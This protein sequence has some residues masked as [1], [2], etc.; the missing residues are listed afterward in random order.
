MALRPLSDLRDYQ[1][2]AVERMVEGKKMAALLRPGLGKTACTLT[3]L[4]LLKPKRTLVVAPAQVVASEVWSREARAWGHTSHL[5]VSEILGS[6]QDR[7][8]FLLQG[9]DIEVISYDNLMWL[10]DTVLKGRYDA[11]VFD[12]LSKM[13]H[14]GTKRFKR[15]RAW[16][17]DIPIRFGLTGSPVGNHYLDLWGE[18]FMVAGEKPLGPTMGQYQDTYFRQDGFRWSIRQDGSVEQIKARIKPFA[19]SL[20]AKLSANQLPEVIHNPIKLKLPKE[21]LDLERQ[22]RKELEIE[23]ESGKTITALNNSKLA[24]AIRQLSSGAIYTCGPEITPRTWE[25][26]H[27]LKLEALRNL[28]DELQGEPLLVFTWF[29]HEAAR[30]QRDF[31]ARVLDGSTKMIDE[32][33]NRT[34]PILVAHPMGS[35]HGLNLQRGGSN[36]V[37][38]TPP[39]SRELFDQGNGRVA[40]IGQSSKLVSA[41]ILLA[42]SIDQRVYSALLSKGEAEADIMAAV[43]L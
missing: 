8:L 38:F 39:W 33:N 43:E 13:K 34:I 12:E 19:F 26:T 17:K 32:W 3:A 27:D 36:V 14:P 23:L 29:K 9:A 41:H 31:K 16:A 28:Q 10:T 20:S 25:E 7:K 6:E 2:D 24:V 5:S 30:L 40:R 4:R 22:L 18:M 21:C 35:G 37:W 11:I 1:I 15:M 42:G